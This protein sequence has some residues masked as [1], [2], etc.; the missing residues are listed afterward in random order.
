MKVNAIIVAARIPPFT[1]RDPRNDL[2]EVVAKMNG[3]IVTVTLFGL[4]IGTTTMREDLEYMMPV[5]S[6][7]ITARKERYIGIAS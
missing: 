1:A 3:S 2:V 5:S 4:R 6:C 7:T